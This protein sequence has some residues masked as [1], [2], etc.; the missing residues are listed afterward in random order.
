MI[1][2]ARYAVGLCAAFSLNLTLFL[3]AAYASAKDVVGLLGGATFDQAASQ[4]NGMLQTDLKTFLD[5]L[6]KTASKLLDHGTA[7]A[8]LLEIQASNSILNIT[9]S[10]RS[11]FANEMDR[12]VSAVSTQ[13]MPFLI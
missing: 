3:G 4:L 10:V 9:S 12:Q 8:S 7:N 6:D 13:V 1:I 2:V 11:Q 5:G